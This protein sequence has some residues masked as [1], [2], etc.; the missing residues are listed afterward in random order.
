MHTRT[1]E[2][3]M[4][5][6]TSATQR[7]SGS[8]EQE[9]Q[10]AAGVERVGETGLAL[11]ME[12]PHGKVREDFL[13]AFRGWLKQYKQATETAHLVQ[14]LVA[15][16]AAAAQGEDTSGFSIKPQ[17]VPLGGNPSEPQPG[18]LMAWPG[19]LAYTYKAME[20]YV[21]NYSDWIPF[22]GG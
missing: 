1:K 14:A 20:N 18:I 4:T 3:A 12:F 16:R 2:T 7:G 21:F 22:F 10:F 9:E 8:K 5:E 13:I 11:R 15:E 6:E 17:V 19:A